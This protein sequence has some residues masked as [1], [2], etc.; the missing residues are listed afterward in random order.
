MDSAVDIGTHV[1]SEDAMRYDSHRTFPKPRKVG[2]GR[3]SDMKLMKLTLLK[4]VARKEQILLKLFNMS[5]T[6]VVYTFNSYS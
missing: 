5:H 1:T 4:L 3:S 2:R 6:R